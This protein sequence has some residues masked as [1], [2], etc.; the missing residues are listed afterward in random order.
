MEIE[1]TLYLVGRADQSH[2]VRQFHREHRVYQGDHGDL[3]RRGDQFHQSHRVHQVDLVCHRDQFHRVVRSDPW[4]RGHRAH[5][6]R[7]VDLVDQNRRPRHPHWHRQDQPE[8]EF[9]Q[10]VKLGL[11]Y[12]ARWTGWTRWTSR[13]GKTGLTRLTILTVVAR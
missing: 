1:H 3:A 8:V 13:A 10:L 7:P 11:T 4:H 2:R 5:Q 9:N 12:R 6:S